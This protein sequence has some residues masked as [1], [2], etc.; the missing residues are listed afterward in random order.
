MMI[1]LMYYFKSRP[2]AEGM[3][4]T[5]KLG[6]ELIGF[7]YEGLV[8]YEYTDRK[9]HQRNIDGCVPRPYKVQC[10]LD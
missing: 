7:R 10:D 2:K 3:D 1:V 4:E 5:S 9:T 6:V 8:K